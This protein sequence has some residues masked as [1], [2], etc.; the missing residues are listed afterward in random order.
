MHVFIIVSY[1]LQMYSLSKYREK[2]DISKH[3]LVPCTT[4]KSIVVARTLIFHIFIRICNIPVS[5]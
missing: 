4:K 3:L 2:I 1:D 5:I